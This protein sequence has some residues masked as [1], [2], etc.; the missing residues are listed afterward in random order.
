MGGFGPLTGRTAEQQ[1]CVAQRSS[2]WSRFPEQLCAGP[3][4]HC[5]HL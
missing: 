4:C 3:S 5:H 1:L 2:G